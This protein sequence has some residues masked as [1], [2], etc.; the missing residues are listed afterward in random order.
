MN[1]RTNP[2]TIIAGLTLPIVSAAWRN[3]V[4]TGGPRNTMTTMSS[5]AL[6]VKR[7][8]RIRRC[9]GGTPTSSRTSAGNSPVGSTP[10]SISWVAS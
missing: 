8:G 6:I 9:G 10:R 1:C 7:N 4:S 2:A 5:S 3:P